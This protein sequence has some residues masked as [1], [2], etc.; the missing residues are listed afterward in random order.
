MEH[1]KN[2]KEHIDKRSK[3]REKK[4]IQT[5][6]KNTGKG[7]RKGKRHQDGRT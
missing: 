4:E 6:K 5:N 2:I 1:T 7:Q 3:E